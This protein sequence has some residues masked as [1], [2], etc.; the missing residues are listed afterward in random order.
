MSARD[1]SGSPPAPEGR[2]DV[3]RRAASLLLH[4]VVATATVVA[5]LVL[6]LNVVGEASDN[7]ARARASAAMFDEG[8]V[9]AERTLLALERSLNSRR[10][11][12]AV[13]AAAIADGVRDR[14]SEQLT[15]A[16]RTVPTRRIDCFSSLGTRVVVTDAKGTVLGAVIAGQDPGRV[17]APAEQASIGMIDGSATGLI[18][19]WEASAGTPRARGALPDGSVV[20]EP[21]LRSVAGTDRAFVAIGSV[22]FPSAT[23]RT[24]IGA[25]V[26][27]LPLETLVTDL[28]PMLSQVDDVYVLD[29]TGKFLL[30]AHEQTTRLLTDLSGIPLV[31]KAI[32]QPLIA[33]SDPVRLREHSADPFSGESR[34]FVTTTMSDFGWQV[35][36]VPEQRQ[37]AAVEATLSQL[38]A[39]RFG[40]GA[41]LAI[42]ALLLT[43][44]LR[45]VTRRRRALAVSLEQQTAT[46]QVLR[47]ISRSA[48]DLDAVLQTV[49]IAAV[50]LC[51]A[52]VG[53]INR[54]DASRGYARAGRTSELEKL[55]DVKVADQGREG[56]VNTRFADTPMGRAMEQRTTVAIS[57]LSVDPRSRDT[58]GLADRIGARAVVAVPLLR[59]G[60][61]I[62]TVLLCRM[63]PRPFT[64]PEVGL[65]E[66]FSDQIVVAMENVRLF[67]ETQQK[68]EE[69]DAASRHKSEFLANMSHELRTPLNAVIGFSDVLEQ[70]LFGELNDRQTEYVRDIGASGRHLLTLVNDVLDLSKV[71]A[72]RMELEI[73]TFS[74]VESVAAALSFVRERAV[75]HDIELSAV[76]PADLGPILADERKVR[77]VLLNL[78]SNA[79]KFT[80]DGGRIEVRVQRGDDLVVS[81]CDT[82]IGIASEDLPKVFDEF[83]QVGQSHEGT[84]LGLTLSKRFIELHGGRIWVESTPGKGSTFSFTL[85]IHRTADVRV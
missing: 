75:R 45:A 6:P 81:V 25:I 46:S 22:V 82:G 77:Q 83:R 60:E 69:L 59:E 42:A 48:F 70:Q 15:A 20:G 3:I 72:G 40:L 8:F 73:S 35:I 80:P 54:L 78:L 26:L 17:C 63:T 47:T 53:W 84:G 14:D 29:R 4:P 32:R 58:G 71:E 62:G 67:T 28:Q 37:M 24:A 9:A 7:E 55:V 21:F 19:K 65:A 33:T 1:P 64:E 2:P 52:D 34:P 51:D 56:F 85:P 44:A 13:T 68:S 79:V 39:A 27:E 49:I 11:D 38:R 18:A 43:T 23:S 74:L 30:S 66:T 50:R 57:D 61:P 31:A 12:V 76:L 5:L 10:T 16:A 41:V 36:V